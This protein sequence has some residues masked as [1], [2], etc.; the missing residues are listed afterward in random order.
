MPYKDLNKRNEHCRNYYW[1]NKERCD[2]R[3]RE[4][5]NIHREQLKENMK[6]YYQNHKDELREYSRQY[7]K[8]NI[9]KVLERQR[10]YGKT[11]QRK[12]YEN[13]LHRE[14]R[15]DSKFIALAMYSEGELKCACCGE[16][17]IEFLTI[18][19][20]NN[21]GAEHRKKFKIWSGWKT[22]D[23]LIK[24]N[25]PEGFQVLCMNCNF[26][27]AHFGHCPHKEIPQ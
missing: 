12:E 27:K 13:K 16:N 17:I 10:I 1:K 5:Y 21:D 4:Y 24:N 9:E 6:Q 2:V 8:R 11:P 3:S 25:F 15:Q 7:R 19:H 14:W 23:W 20:V 22:Y 26:A 18:D